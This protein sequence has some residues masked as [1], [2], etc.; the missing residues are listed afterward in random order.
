M[1]YKIDIQATT[2]Y[3]DKYNE[4][5]DCIYCQNY[6]MM[7]STVYPEVVKILHG[8]GI[9]LKR[10][11]EVVE[12]YW[13]DARDRRRYESFYSVKGVLFVD[14]LEIYNKDAIITLYNPDT[15]AHIYSNTGMESPYFILAISNI[16]LPWVMQ[17][18]PND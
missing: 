5:C 12:C 11:L 17:E 8:F 3:A 7:F 13:N 10:P 16:E 9:Q 14:K 15:N 6:E 1:K 2:T 18:N 4:P